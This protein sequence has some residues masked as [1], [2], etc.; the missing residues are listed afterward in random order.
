[1]DEGHEDAVNS[2][3]EIGHHGVCT[4]TQ[5]RWFQK[6]LSESAYHGWLRICA[7]HHNIERGCR[8]D[9]ENLRDADMLGN[10]L[11]GSLDLTLHGHTH[12]AK[13]GQLKHVPMY[14]TGSAALKTHDA[15]VVPGVR[16]QYQII[17]IKRDSLIRH[18]RR[19]NSADS[20]PKW[21]GDTSLSE[22]GD[23][24]IVTTKTDFSSAI[25]TLPEN[26]EA[27]SQVGLKEILQLYPILGS[28]SWPEQTSSAD[29]FLDRVAELTRLRFENVQIKTLQRQ[30]NDL[31]CLNV[32]YRTESGILVSRPIA[33][34]LTCPTVDELNALRNDIVSQYR[35]VEP[36]LFADCICGDEAALTQELR[37]HANACGVK[38]QRIGEYRGLI[39]L[40]SFIE[41]QTQRIERLQAA[42]GYRTDWY[43]NQRMTIETSGKRSSSKDALTTITEWM[44]Q[45]EPTFVL[46]LGEPVGWQRPF[47]NTGTRPSPGQATVHQADSGGTA[48]YGKIEE[49]CRDAGGSLCRPHAV[50]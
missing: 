8:D 14:S 12:H 26:D 33:T 44:Q 9:N 40:T 27:F 15:K 25:E 22:T 32:S 48:T 21:I 29:L 13:S 10:I 24:W 4:E 43:V 49:R 47:S 41:G 7:V 31:R 3:H 28:S 42:A 45:P 30:R 19:Y 39:D 34:T 1:M 2:L 36:R 11:G 16:N 50:Q 37:S 38:L 46:L 6:R 35:A 20:P 18:G 23:D 5:L 17:T